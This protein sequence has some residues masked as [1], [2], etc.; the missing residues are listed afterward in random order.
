MIAKLFL[1]GNGQVHLIIGNDISI[2]FLLFRRSDWVA[3]NRSLGN[4]FGDSTDRFVGL[5]NH[6]NT[7]GSNVADG[8]SLLFGL[9]RAAD[10]DTCSAFPVAFSAYVDQYNLQQPEVM[11]ASDLLAF[12]K[13]IKAQMKCL[14]EYEKSNAEVADLSFAISELIKAVQIRFENC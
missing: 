14:L 3:F 9:S 8:V 11:T 1:W 6:G 12:A 10:L 2:L 7:F 5:H 13:L 4:L